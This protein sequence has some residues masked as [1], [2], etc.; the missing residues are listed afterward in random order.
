[1][2]APEWRWL[3]PG[4][5]LSLTYPFG[6]EAYLSEARRLEEIKNLDKTPEGEYPCRP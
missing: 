6:L 4:S 1:M 3:F 5:F 2:S